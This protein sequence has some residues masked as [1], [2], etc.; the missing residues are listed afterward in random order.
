MRTLHRLDRTPENIYITFKSWHHRNDVQVLGDRYDFYEV[1]TKD[2]RIADK[3]FLHEEDENGNELPVDECRV[4]DCDGNTLLCGMDNI[5]ADTGILDMGDY[6]IEVKRLSECEGEAYLEALEVECDSLFY[7]DEVRA[8]IAQQRGEYFVEALKL[9]NSNLHLF[10]AEGGGRD[11]CVENL[12]WCDS[13][14]DVYDVLRE[15][16]NLCEFSAR[17]VAQWPLIGDWW[18]RHTDEYEE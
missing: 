11:V 8:Y 5:A 9:Y 2:E 6:D 10:F 13:E 14:D 7:R 3:L 17:E 12:E 16:F 1:I 4:V 15:E 18:G